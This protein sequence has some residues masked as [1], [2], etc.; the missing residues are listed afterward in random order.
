MIFYKAF[1]KQLN[2]SFSWLYPIDLQADLRLLCDGTDSCTDP[3]QQS[4]LV[5]LL[6]FLPTKFPP[7]WGRAPERIF[8]FQLS[9]SC[10]SYKERVAG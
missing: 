10:L 2:K 9:D 6:A 8:V 4:I 5:D 3:A 7:P 1:Y